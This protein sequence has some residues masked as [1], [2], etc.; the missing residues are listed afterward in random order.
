MDWKR[1]ACGRTSAQ[2][3]LVAGMRTIQEIA[4]DFGDAHQLVAEIRL[5]LEA[6]KKEGDL[7]VFLFNCD[8]SISH[9]ELD[10]LTLLLEAV[11]G[12][13]LCYA[14]APLS[15]WDRH[16]DKWTIYKRNNVTA[17]KAGADR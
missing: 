17:E 5:N 10:K 2:F 16:A 3:D 8:S 12:A 4:N 1:R 9:V 11:T 13:A 15:D 6:K 7:L 14:C